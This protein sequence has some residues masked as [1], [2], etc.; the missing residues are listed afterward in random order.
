M[1]SEVEVLR[2]PF[3][4]R[5]GRPNDGKTPFIGPLCLDCYVKT[6]QLVCVPDRIVLPV[7]KSCFSVRV[8]YKWMPSSGF[9]DIIERI[10]PQ[11]LSRARPCKEKVRELRLVSITPLST[12]SWRTVVSVK[13]AL[14]LDSVDRFIDIEEQ[15]VLQ[16]KP[17]LCPICKDD[18]GGEY[19]VLVQVRGEIDRVGEVLEKTIEDDPRITNSLLDIIE[20]QNGF[21]VYFYDR[22]A[23][24]KFLRRLSHYF[25]LSVKRSSEE[26][27]VN[28][29]GK[30]RH[31]LV[32]S[33][34]IQAKRGNKAK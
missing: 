30:T 14:L 7:C 32:I 23:A 26:V 11:I 3:C 20:Q 24:N 9:N 31:R 34:R 29:R 15:I 2:V 28:S 19:H 25:T 1:N 13:Y 22:G 5:C 33:A 4:I 17:T 8:G 18:R 16:L 21:D 6:E 10:L 12:P 27:G